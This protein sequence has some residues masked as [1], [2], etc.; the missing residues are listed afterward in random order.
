MQGKKRTVL[1]LES[2]HTHRTFG[3]SIIETFARVNAPLKMKVYNCLRA[4][5]KYLFLLPTDASFQPL[6]LN[7]NTY[8]KCA[9]NGS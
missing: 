1:A 2:P 6:K 8:I 3:T 7:L 5:C 9:T 4:S